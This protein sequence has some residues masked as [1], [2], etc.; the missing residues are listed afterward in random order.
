MGKAFSGLAVV[1]LLATA[2]AGAAQEPAA[3]PGVSTIHYRPGE[4]NLGDVQ[5]FFW[6]GQYH[7]FY[8][9]GAIWEHV[10]SDDLVHWKQL[11]TAIGLT[12]EERADGH[13]CIW[14]GSIVEHNGTFH[15]FYTDGGPVD[16]ADGSQAIAHAVSEDLTTWT[17]L[18]EHTFVGDG[19]HYWSKAKNPPLKRMDDDQSFRDPEVFWN[20]DEEVWM[21]VFVARDLKTHYHVHGLATSKDLYQW[22][23]QD[24]INK[25]PIRHVDC[26]DIVKIGKRWYLLFDHC[27]YKVADNIRGPYEPEN[28]L[29]FETPWICVPRVMFDG[30][31]QVLAAGWISD[32]YDNRDDSI[33]QWGGTL[34][35]SRELYAAA[36]GTLLQK[37]V[38]E[39]I[40]AYT[41]TVLALRQ[42]P[43]LSFGYKP[44]AEDTP[45]KYNDAGQLAGGQN[46]NPFYHGDDKGYLSYKIRSCSFDVPEDYMMHCRFQLQPGIWQ[47]DP[48][49]RSCFTITVRQ[50]E[51]ALGGYHLIY[52]PSKGEIEVKTRQIGHHRKCAV[53]PSKP[54]D[55]RV[56]VTGSV[57]E[58]FVNDAYAFTMRGYDYTEGQLSFT[59]ARCA[60]NIT[61]LTVKVAG[62]NGNENR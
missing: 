57:I 17:K 54:I 61:D 7:V 2:T 21:M 32:M 33:L 22:E 28:P 38:P 19:I 46:S 4:G 52:Y 42:K 35:I 51:N 1:L 43:E 36:D 48:H 16:R 12:G 8:I 47:D 25:M 45:W 5:V 58:W 27:M 30:R 39:I 9:G 11:P 15:A 3:E 26:P 53:D 18:P 23:Q 40:A 6:K 13:Y 59:T 29:Q 20:E 24:Y 60:V 44:N 31:R 56:F 49:G 55:V 10:V 41:K 14:S 62:K 50:P 37:P 34:G